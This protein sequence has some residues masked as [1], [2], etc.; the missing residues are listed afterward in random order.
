MNL[1]I[2]ALISTLKLVALGVILYAIGYKIAQTFTVEQISLGISTIGTV[3]LLYLIFDLKL[4]QLKYEEQ[5][6]E[7]ID[8]INKD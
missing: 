6:N 2:R 4:S 8:K 5:L 1:Q 3:Y 7:T